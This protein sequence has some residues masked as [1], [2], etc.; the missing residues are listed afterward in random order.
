MCLNGGC[1][2][3]PQFD[4]KR[5][6]KLFSK[7]KPT[8]VAGVPTL[9]EALLTNKYMENMDM[10]YWKYA[11]CGGDSLTEANYHYTKGYHSWVK[12]LLGLTSYKNYGVSGYTISSV[13]NKVNSISDTS[14]IIFIMCGVNDENFSTPLGAFGDSTTSTIYGSYDVLCKKLK[15]KYPTKL[16]V[17]ITPHYQTK[18]PHNSGVTSYEVSKAMKEVCEKHTIPVY[19]N[20]ILSGIY[21]TNLSYWTTDNCH[22]NDKAHEMLGR[23]LSK[24]IVDTFRYYYG[25]VEEEEPDT[26][27]VP[28]EPDVPEVTLTS[29]S[30]TYTGGDVVVGTSVNSLTGITVTGTYSDGSTSPITGYTLS[31]T[32]VEGSN[33]ITVSYGGKSTTFTVNGIQEEPSVNFS[34]VNN[35][36][37][38]VNYENDTLTIGTN[39]Q[40]FGC[41]VFENVNEVRLT[42]YDSLVSATQ[43]IGWFAVHDNG[44]YHALGFVLS[45]KKIELWD[46]DSTI[47]NATNNKTLDIEYPQSGSEFLI[48]IEGENVNYY[49]NGTL[50]HTFKGDKICYIASNAKRKTING[51][52]FK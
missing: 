40:T 33:T 12:E 39:N 36:Y 32:I 37:A 28:V 42:I 13:Y 50:I 7:Y 35:S 27:D 4:A 17:F 29:I 52:T 6:D 15:E 18:Y 3:V 2:L 5:I 24:F 10:S 11:I 14:D 43:P 44:V 41:V 38:S 19:D 46:F 16:I 51:I 22:W 26:P 34:I 30:A 1:I 47:T 23:N 45:T 48:K 25:Y 49:D 8:L 31:G 9:Y 21:S 20:F